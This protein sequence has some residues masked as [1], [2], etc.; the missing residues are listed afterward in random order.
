MDSQ[1]CPWPSLAKMKAI[2]IGPHQAPPPPPPPCAWTL[3]AKSSARRASPRKN[4]TGSILDGAIRG[5]HRRVEPSG[6]GECGEVFQERRFKSSPCTFSSDYKPKSDGH[7][8]TERSV[9]SFSAAIKAVT[10]VGPKTLYRVLEENG[11]KLGECWMETLPPSGHLELCVPKRGEIP[12][13]LNDQVIEP[14]SNE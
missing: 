12:R 1:G 14:K 4:P 8:L 2:P 13:P 11:N 3:T 7:E 6:P 5:F 9:E 10:L